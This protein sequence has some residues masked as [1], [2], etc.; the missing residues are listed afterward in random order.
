MN[1]D[2]KFD[3]VVKDLPISGNVVVALSGGADSTALYLLAK[4]YYVNTPIALIIDHKMRSESTDE[5]ILVKQYIESIGGVAHILTYK[6]KRL[7][8]QSDARDARYKLLT[9]WCT[10]NQCDYLF[11]GHNLND[12]IENF[13]IRLERGTG[14]AGLA[15]I[16]KISKYN[17][18]NIIRPLLEVTRSEIEQYLISQNITWVNDPSNKQDKY[19]RSRVRKFLFDELGDEIAIKRIHQTQLNLTRASKAIDNMVMSFYNN[20]VVF[21]DN[22]HSYINIDKLKKL[23]EEIALRV[24]SRLVVAIAGEKDSTGR[25]KN[26]ENFYY[27]IMNNNFK[28]TTFGGCLVFIKN[29]FIYIEGEKI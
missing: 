21:I 1:I 22:K 27:K 26:L 25:L 9:N 2:S 16:K 20:D 10:E 15:N 19:L 14:L 12:D 28:K 6:Q 5:A 23:E 8:N 7:K 11:L 29:N 4:K 13:L 3:R 18:I 24:L 17:D